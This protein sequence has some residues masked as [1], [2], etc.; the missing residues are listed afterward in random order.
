MTSAVAGTVPMVGLRLPVILF[1]PTGI[2]DDTGILNRADPLLDGR[3]VG[4]YR[5]LW[6]LVDGSIPS[7][8][9][10]GHMLASAEPPSLR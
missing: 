2:Q 10:L 9:P 7:V 4:S 5:A 3:Q 1:M 6:R 8:R